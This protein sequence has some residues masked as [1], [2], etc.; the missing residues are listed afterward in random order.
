MTRSHILLLA[1]LLLTSCAS[2]Q[3]SIHPGD[4]VLVDAHNCY[5][6]GEWWADRMD[7]ALAGGV[8]VAIEQD[9]FWDATRSRSVL[10][11]EAPLKGTEPGMETY[12]FERIRP[13]VEMALKDPDHSHW[14]LITLNLDFKSEEPAHLRATWELLTK[15]RAWLTT[16]TKTN[17]PHR[18]EPLDVGPVLVLTGESDAQQKIFFDDLPQGGR[19]LAF[20]AVHTH[21]QDRKAPPAIIAPEPASNYRRWWNSPWFMVEPEGQTRAGDWTARDEQR[22]REIV[23]HAHANGLWM[24]FYTLDGAS[25]SERSAQ[26]LFASYSF[27]TM[28]AARRRWLAAAQA[29]VDYIATDHYED[30]AALLA[31]GLESRRRRSTDKEK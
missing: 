26:G 30:L 18:P 11:H 19:L 20:G 7:R 2:A 28:Q 31:P 14:P 4:R 25:Q 23:N 6:Y 12:A 22:L 21:N 5:P 3:T 9:L 16:A 1:S 24:R 15:Y 29:G 17:T 8:P 27:T 10:A 13:L